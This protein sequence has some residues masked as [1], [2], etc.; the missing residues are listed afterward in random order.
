MLNKYSGDLRA[1]GDAGWRLDVSKVLYNAVQDNSVD[2]DPLFNKVE[3]S[4]FSILTSPSFGLRPQSL[5]NV[6]DPL[7]QLQLRRRSSFS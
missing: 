7:G 6:L 5:I 3:T 1:S 4:F 2:D